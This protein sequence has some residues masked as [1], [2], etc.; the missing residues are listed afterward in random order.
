[1]AI[2]KKMIRIPIKPAITIPAS[3]IALLGSQ[4]YFSYL[5]ISDNGTYN[6]SPNLK[7]TV[8]T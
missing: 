6:E 4:E 5:V 3:P 8:S 7:R 1:M 2:T